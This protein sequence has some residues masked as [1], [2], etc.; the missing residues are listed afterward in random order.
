MLK[1]AQNIFN[2]I[3]NIS[4]TLRNAAPKNFSMNMVP[5]GISKIDFNTPLN[6]I[7][8]DLFAR[9]QAKMEGFFAN[10]VKPTLAQRNNNPGNLRHGAFTTRMGGVLGE[11]GFARFPNADAGF[12]AMK[13]LYDSPNYKNLTVGQA[14]HRWAPPNEN[15][16]DYYT[17]TMI[18]WYNQ[19]GVK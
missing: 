12:N 16:T 9:N 1:F 2:E 7:N 14:M 8:K 15:A 6:L 3:K 18:N 5:K 17:N 19:G 13:A 4:N 10:T 11:G